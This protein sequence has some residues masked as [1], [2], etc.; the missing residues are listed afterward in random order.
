MVM[1]GNIDPGDAAYSQ[2]LVA[3]D[4]SCSRA[5]PRQVPVTGTGTAATLGIIADR[6]GILRFQQN[7][8]QA[9]RAGLMGRVVNYL[10]LADQVL[11]RGP[12]ET[13]FSDPTS[14]V[15]EKVFVGP[16]G[17]PIAKCRLSLAARASR[18]LR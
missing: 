9:V 2:F 13:A 6:L 4:T 18:V 10:G 7:V 3:T 8:A 14:G 15:A 11:L 12:L 5:I 1:I 16:G 17:D